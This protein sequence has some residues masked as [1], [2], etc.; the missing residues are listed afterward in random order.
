MGDD[1]R[2][3][4]S[5][6]GDRE[7]ILDTWLRSSADGRGRVKAS[8]AAR[9]ARDIY[10]GRVRVWVLCLADAPVYVIGWIARDAGG[11]I[12]VYVRD[13]YRGNGFGRKLKG[14]DECSK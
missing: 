13:T 14:H 10:G 9:V 4:P 6:A 7:F 3:R 5:T 2:V 11:V 1:I 8:R 12:W